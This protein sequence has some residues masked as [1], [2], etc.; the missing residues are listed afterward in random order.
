MANLTLSIDDKLLQAARVRAVK[1]R[2][3]VNEICRQALEAYAR[4]S[5]QQ[6]LERY[7]RVQAGID[8]A[9]RTAPSPAPW[10]SRDEMYEQV[11]D[12]RHPTLRGAR[13]KPAKSP[14]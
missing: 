6:R 10:K 5:G 9:P 12:E 11:L 3:S 7:L 1:E 8:T 2:T 13:K 14:A 4:A